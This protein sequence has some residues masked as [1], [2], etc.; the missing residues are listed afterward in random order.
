MYINGEKMKE[1]DYNLY[2]APMTEAN[3]LRYNGA[4]GNKQLV[5]GF[6]QDKND[7]TIA[8]DWAK[9][10]NQSNKHF[11]GL[12][13]NVRVFHKALT[14]KEIQMMYDSEKP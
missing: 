12:L 14:E 4:P 2:D 7:P 13:D 11:K 10:E 5:F 3:G 1:Q 6:I 8:D 9:Y